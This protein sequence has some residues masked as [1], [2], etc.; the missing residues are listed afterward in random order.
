MHSDCLQLRASLKVI[1]HDWYTCMCAS[2]DVSEAHA[3]VCTPLLSH[4]FTF[5]VCSSVL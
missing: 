4:Q 3:E 2:S 5:P 1:P